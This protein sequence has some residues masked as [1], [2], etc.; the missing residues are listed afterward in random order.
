[1]PQAFLTPIYLEFCSGN[2]F[3]VHNYRRLTPTSMRLKFVCEGI[4]SS[5]GQI[6][7]GK[8][9]ISAK[10]LATPFQIIDKALKPKT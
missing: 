4:I 9:S 10:N 2:F 7:S 1:M 3:Q 5:D 6:A 8:A